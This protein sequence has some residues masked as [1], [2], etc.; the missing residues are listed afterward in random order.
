VSGPL[1]ERADNPVWQWLESVQETSALLGAILF[2]MHPELYR[3]GMEAYRTI[4][5]NPGLVKESG[6]VLELLTCW[7]SPFS[8]MSVLS[9]RETIFHRDV[10]SRNEWYDML[11]TMGDYKN[12]MMELPGLGLRLKYDPGTI[13]GIGGK[14]VRHGVSSCDGNRVCLAYFFRHKVLERLGVEPA[15]YSSSNT[16]DS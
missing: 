6:V 1:K 16:Y 5:E 7:M 4:L 14:V 13:V 15:G 2:I 12:G 10:Q 9:N 11:V 8:G 3:K